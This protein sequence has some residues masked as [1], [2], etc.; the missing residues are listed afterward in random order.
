VVT[1]PEAA[2]AQVF[3]VGMNGSGTTMLRDHLANHSRIYGFPSET[4]SIPY[5]INHQR[6]FGDLADESAFLALWAAVLGS[7][8]KSGHLL[9]RNLTLPGTADRSAAGCFDHIMR[10]LASEQGKSIWCEKTPMYVHHMTL[11]GAAFPAARF[12]HV[13]RDGRD[14]AASFHRR[15]K[16]NPVRTVTRWKQA[17][18]D[19][20]RQ[21]EALGTRYLEIRYEEFTEAPEPAFRSLLD[22]LGLPF[23]PAVLSASARASA[24]ASTSLAEEIIRNPRK[25]ERYFDRRTLERIEEVCGRLLSELGYPA[26]NPTGDLD[27]P[28]WRLRWWRLTDDARRFLMVA[29]LSGRILRPSNWRYIATRTRNALKQRA[30]SKT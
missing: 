19:G 28:A 22:F 15:W 27:P 29:V 4:R 8:S 26:R 14:C 9:P 30:T 24:D 5:F 17:V 10:H 25:G 13:I 6:E 12:I 16:F 1:H 21:G 23:E 20:R 18:R 3:V 2:P 11:L 7:V